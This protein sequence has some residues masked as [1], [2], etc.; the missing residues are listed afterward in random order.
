MSHVDGTFQGIQDPASRPLGSPLISAAAAV[1][2][3]I[4]AQA[5]PELTIPLQVHFTCL[6]LFRRHGC[7][8]DLHSSATRTRKCRELVPLRTSSPRGS[9]SRWIRALPPSSRE[10]VWGG[11]LNT[12]PE[13]RRSQ[14]LL[15]TAATSVM[16]P[17]A[18][19]PLTPAFWDHSPNKLL[20]P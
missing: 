1:D 13:P 3:S 7:V 8:L 2:S 9:R 20:G 15:Q 10:I 17:Y 16:H 6:S 11:I 4:Q 12:S 14:P 18:P 19:C 5:P